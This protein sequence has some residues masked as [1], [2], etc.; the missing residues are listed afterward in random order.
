MSYNPQVYYVRIVTGLEAKRLMVGKLGFN[1]KTQLPSKPIL[2]YT[3]DKMGIHRG[4]IDK[5]RWDVS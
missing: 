5:T 4:G 3:V 2:V 1:L